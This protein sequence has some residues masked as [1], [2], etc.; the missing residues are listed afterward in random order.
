MTDFEQQ[1]LDDEPEFKSKSQIKREMEE[2]QKL[3]AKLIDLSETQLQRIPMGERLDKAVREA[4]TMK[5]REGRRR[6]LQFIGK[7]MRDSDSEAI[8]KAYERASSTGQEHTKILHLSEQWREKLLNQPD[9]LEKFL[10]EYPS[11]DRQHLRQLIRNAQ[12]EQSQNKPPATA[13]KLFRHLRELIE[14]QLDLQGLPD[15]E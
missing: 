2:L 6:Q 12:K 14:Q 9:A 5:H 8:R 13:R 10:A 11:A 15:S 4:R 3:G 7:L 1:P